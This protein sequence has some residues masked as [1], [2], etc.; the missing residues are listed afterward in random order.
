VEAVTPVLAS[1]HP[2]AIIDGLHAQCSG[3]VISQNK[4]KK[5]EQPADG[6]TRRALSIDED[7]LTVG[8]S[9]STAARGTK[10]S[11]LQVMFTLS[12]VNICVLQASLVEEMIAISAIERARE[13]TCVSLLTLCLDSLSCQVLINHHSQK[14]LRAFSSSAAKDAITSTS[15]PPNKRQTSADS[16]GSPENSQRAAFEI[17]QDDDLGNLH[18]AHIHCQLR[19]MKRNSNFSDS[20]MLTAIPEYRS[21]VLFTFERGTVD[22]F[23]TDDTYG[24]SDVVEDLA[25]FVMF[26]CGMEGTDL[27][28][29]RRL[30][31]DTPTTSEAQPGN[32]AGGAA[33]RYQRSTSRD[34]RHDDFAEATSAEFRMESE[35]AGESPTR[36]S[37]PLA[38]ETDAGNG[39]I[40]GNELKGNMSSFTLEFQTVWF[41][42]AAPPP[43]P[44][45]KKL[46]YTR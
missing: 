34:S 2:S 6:D 39:G 45:K 37:S 1:L 3:T 10:T 31:Y 32:V 12:R 4:L 15:A 21:K 11:R 9:D 14:F 29:A 35:T 27:K 26:E 25:G 8:D 40:G 5:S 44:S 13:L 41:N 33:G 7:L 19:R 43:S 46:E 38:D 18:I 23:N 16:G 17:N 28:I 42:F 24:K 30:G 22:S 36:M 20:V